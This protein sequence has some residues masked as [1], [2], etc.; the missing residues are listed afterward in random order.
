MTTAMAP[1]MKT[2]VTELLGTRYPIIQGGMMWVGRAELAA[3]VS[4]AGGFGILTALTQPTP[5]ELV[6]EIARCREMT[7][8]PFGVNLTIL[9]SAKPPPYEAYLDAAL[10]NGIKVIETAGNN[11]KAFIDKAKARGVKIVHK[12]TAV[13]HALSAERNG[14]DAISIDGYECAG[15]PGED[16]VG[17]LILFAVAARKVKIPLI[18]SGGIG[19]GATFAAALALG[20]EG[21][22]M[23]T[24]FCAVKEAPIHDSIKQ[25]MV[26]RTE[27]DTTLIFRTLHNTGRV[28]KTPVSQ[29]VVA[30]ENRPGGCEFK[31]I[32]HLVT[33]AKGRVALEEGDETQGLIWA[34]QVL[35]LIDDV[36]TCHELIQ[37]LV[38]DCREQL[39]KG[40][41][42]F[43]S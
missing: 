6:K 38:R 17:G 30:I 8:Q 43:G 7:D 23:G 21:I 18:A 39:A 9:P 14:V 29:E 19:D 10:D 25:L 24:R 20:A 4:N 32:H 2:R 28:M 31:D 22:N 16:G 15:H 5:E 12:C 13:R 35:G 41:R 40:Q 42:A 11:P 26:E 3:A 33:G 27:R 36:P 1:A 37:R 34:G